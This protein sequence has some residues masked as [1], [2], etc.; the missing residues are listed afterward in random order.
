MIA[1]P[2]REK[3]LGPV[4]DTFD[5]LVAQV[6]T[7]LGVQ[8]NP[9]GSHSNVTAETVSTGRV[10]FADIVEDAVAISPQNNYNPLGLSTAA[11]VRINS[12]VSPLSITGIQVPLGDDS[13][14]LDGRVLVIENTSTSNILSL[15]HEHTASAPRNRVIIP[16]NP[17]TDVTTASFY[18]MPFG[19]ALLVYNAPQARWNIVS[20]PSDELVSYSEIAS[21]QNDYSPSGTRSARVWRIAPTAS[22]LNISGFV[23]SSTVAPRRI[24]IVNEGVYAFSILHAS[25]SSI[26]ANRVYC[27][28]GVRYTLNPREAVDLYRNVDNTW[29]LAVSEKA[30]AWW[31]V[32]YAS[33]NFTGTTGTWTVQSGDQGTYNYQIDGNKMT[34]NFRLNATTTAG[35]CTALRIAVPAGRTCAR[36]T[37]TTFTYFDGTS[38]KVGLLAA[39]AG[40]TTLR[41]ISDW[42]GTAFANSTNGFS[43]AGQITFM[44]QD[45]AAG[46]SELHN[47]VAHVD[48]AHADA[49]HSDV[50]HADVAHTD[51]HSDVAHSDSLHSDT[52]H[53]DVAH[54]D[55]S[56]VD[57][58]SDVGHVDQAHSDVAHSDTAHQD[59]H[60]DTH[61]DASPGGHHAD[62]HGDGHTDVAHQDVTHQDSAHSDTVHNDTHSDTAHTDVTHADV[63][64]GD[65]GHSD[66]AHS[67]AHV[68]TPAHQDTAHVDGGHSDT[69]HSDTPHLDAGFH[70]DASHADIG[71]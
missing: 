27:P 35:G 22:N 49:D 44:I 68:D 46:M 59:L 12:S 40:A 10:V 21:S 57:S 17:A 30:D 25:T 33:G 41:L 55:V 51:S 15:E 70:V 7:I 58:H 5:S 54:S 60:G 8:H 11:I 16:N 19:L 43:L 62:A 9:D 56:H 47:D 50:A 37:I 18:V 48:A 67:D 24:T 66:T 2:N 1:L 65:A 71:V 14:V 45:A 36:D 63:L 61:Q 42:L 6:R 38:S 31:D 20:R 53:S 28:G 13:T 34:V 26:A 3:I 4:R 29:R 32:T 69:A 52:A 64:H 39:D 23:S